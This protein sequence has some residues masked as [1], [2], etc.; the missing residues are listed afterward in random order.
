MIKL[1]SVNI[2]G[3]NNHETVTPFLLKESAYVVCIQEIFEEDKE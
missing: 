1:V 2:Q 3:D